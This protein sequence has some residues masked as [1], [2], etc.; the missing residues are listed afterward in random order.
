MKKDKLRIWL[1]I[2]SNDP[3]IVFYLKDKFAQYE[4]N[5]H[6]N[7]QLEIVSWGRVWPALIDAFKNNTA[8]DIIQIGTSWVRTFAYMGY[9]DQMPDYFEVKPSINQGINK[10]CCI[11]DKQYAAPWISDTIIM[12][13]RKDYM[14]RLGIRPEDVKDWQGLKE[15]AADLMKRRRKKPDI[16]KPLSIA[17][18]AERD[19]IQRFF[20]ILWS[21]GW[22]FPA[23]DK[24]SSKIIMDPDVLDTIKFFAEL[25]IIC[26]TSDDINKHPYQVNEDF[27]LHGQSMFYIGSW[28]GI[29]SRVNGTNHDDLSSDKYCVLPFPT[30]VNKSSSYGGGTVLAVSSRSQKKKQAWRLVQYLCSDDFMIEWSSISS[31]APAFECEFWQKRFNDERVKLLY[32]QTVNSRV[33]PPYPAWLAIEYEIIK[34]VG[35]TLLELIS[36]QNTEIGSEAYTFLQKTDMKIKRIL[37]MSWGD[38]A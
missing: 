6:I 23:L 22:E 25:K 4:L 29:I 37:E 21:Q 7:I 20:S 11:K 12:A 16:P 5:N 15:V 13:G 34:G 30:S 32:Q 27:Y 33:Y 18:K 26:D 14:S 10:I 24:V 2:S 17:L 1:I 3:M 38:E 31:N 35:F 8:P 28:Y 36:K 9:L 19:T